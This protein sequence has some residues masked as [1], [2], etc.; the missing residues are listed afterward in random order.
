MTAPSQPS[1]PAPAPAE[2][3][4]PAAVPRRH[5]ARLEWVDAARGYSVAAVV[6]AHVVLWH[7]TDP[8]VP[9]AGV[10][11]SF[12]D[13]VY[14]LMGSVRMPVL[15]AVSGLVMAR[16]VRAGFVE[17]GL[18]LRSVRNYYLYVVWLVVYA[19]FYAVVVEPTLPHRVDGVGDVVRQLVV[20]ETTLWY[21]YALAVYIAVLGALHRV[22]AWVVLTAL[23]VLSIVMHVTTTSDQVWSK[24]PELAVY[25]ALGV[26]GADLLRRLADRA[27]VLVV[28]LAGV[29]AAGVTLCGRFTAG[30]EVAEAVLFLVR[31]AAF[32]VLAVALVAVGVRWS[33]VRRLG[34]ALGRRTLPIYVLHPLWIALV[35]LAAAGFAHDALGDVLGSPVGALLYPLV[36]AA[37]VIGL[38]LAT[39]A[40]VRRVHLRVPLFE[41]PRA[42]VAQLDRPT[43]ARKGRTRA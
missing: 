25:F 10:G 1:T 38:C 40:L 20:P 19:L 32:L 7:M 31:G 43:Q 41:M 33:P 36:L 8:G 21:V 35:L 5:A 14:G 3:R 23:S 22:P 12:W 27:S 26:Y 16:R 4:A 39:E 2:D 30:N 6:V 34:V 37:A 17:G 42:W 13:R 18:L 15:L 9:I 11:A 28:G 24:V 29:L